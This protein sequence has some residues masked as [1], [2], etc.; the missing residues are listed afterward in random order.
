MRNWYKF[1]ARSYKT[2]LHKIQRHMCNSLSHERI[3]IF[4]DFKER[5]IL[6]QRFFAGDCLQNTRFSFKK[7]QLIS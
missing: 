4:G 5:F 1:L 3:Q 7:I 6:C 2:S